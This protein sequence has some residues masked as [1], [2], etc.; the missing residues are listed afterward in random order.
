MRL[1]VTVSLLSPIR[2]Q[3]ILTRRLARATV[4]RI[5]VVIQEGAPWRTHPFLDGQGERRQI[6]R[7]FGIDITL[8]ALLFDFGRHMN[9]RL[10]ATMSTSFQ[11]FSCFQARRATSFFP[12]F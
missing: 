8:V 12:S 5:E 10:L 11:A 7:G 1:W 4:S 2:S 3:L 6:H 9:V